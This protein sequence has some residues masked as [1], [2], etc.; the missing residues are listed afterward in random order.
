MRRSFCI[1]TNNNKIIE[2]MLFELENSEL[3]ELYITSKTFKNYKNVILHYKGT[4]TLDFYALIAGVITNV[5]IDFYEDYII[6]NFLISNYFYFSDLERKEIQN[7]CFE[8]LESSQK[9]KLLRKNIVFSSCF[10]YIKENKSLILD[11]FIN[12]RLK[13][14]MKDLDELVDLAVDK[15]VIDREYNEFTS[16][17]KLYINTKKPEEQT[18]HLVYQSQESILLN[19]DKQIIDT[20]SNIFDAKYLSDISFSSNDYALNALLNLLPSNLYIHLIDEVKDEFIDTLER[21]FE[22]RVHICKDCAIC[23]IYRLSKPKIDKIKIKE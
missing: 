23:N 5:V 3:E 20:S 13:E 1:K 12:F 2:Y 7:Y 18:I 6:K 14:Y 10:D 15:F 9:E 21:I 19:E 17:L 22:K 8:L 4:E 16:L 11:G